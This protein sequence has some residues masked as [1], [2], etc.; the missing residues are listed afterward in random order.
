MKAK[1]I[2]FITRDYTGLYNAHYGKRKP[3]CAEGVWEVRGNDDACIDDLTFHNLT[4]IRL[5]KGGLLDMSTVVL[6]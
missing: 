1:K 4:N 5:A 3:N 6:K 2:T